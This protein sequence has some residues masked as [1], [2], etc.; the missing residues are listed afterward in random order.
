M[1]LLKETVGREGA[2]DLNVSFLR[3]S[4]KSVI[5][6]KQNKSIKNVSNLL[7]TP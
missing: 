4:C 5:I 6:S 2:Q 3:T 7:K 1:I